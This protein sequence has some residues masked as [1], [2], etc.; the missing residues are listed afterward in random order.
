M[1]AGLSFETSRD[2]SR[3][4]L[5]AGESIP[6]LTEIRNEQEKEKC[7]R[8]LEHCENIFRGEETIKPEL[9][10]FFADFD[11]RS[12]I[13]SQAGMP[14]WVKRG[15]IITHETH[16]MDNTEVPDA[17]TY[18]RMYEKI[19]SNDKLGEQ[20]EEFLKNNKYLADTIYTYAQRYSRPGQENQC[21][22]ALCG[23]TM[24][25]LAWQHTQTGR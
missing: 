15:C 18:C 22:L 10:E 25:E 4:V 5:N 13:F 23:A 8:A 2:D 6:D 3:Y 21:L 1:S 7:H 9:T 20:V 24:T 12:T 11:G 16:I 19:A 17:A 14:E